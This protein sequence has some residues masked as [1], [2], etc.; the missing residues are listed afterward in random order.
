MRENKHENIIKFSEIT[1]EWVLVAHTLVTHAP[2]AVP[3]FSY[4]DL[5]LAA[6]ARASDL[7]VSVAVDALVVLVL[8]D[9]VVENDDE[10]EDPSPRPRV[11]R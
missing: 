2:C 6:V 8:N 4:F 10:K 11:V 3:A 1:T 9:R 7:T 5:S